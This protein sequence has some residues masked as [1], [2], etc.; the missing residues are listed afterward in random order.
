MAG[1]FN[2]RVYGILI[3]QGS[4]L[5]SEEL[6]AGRLITKFPGGGLE[7]GE[8]PRQCLVREWKEELGWEIDVTGHYYTTDFFQKSAFDDSQVI[9]IYYQVAS[10][11]PFPNLV[12][13]VP[14]HRPFWLEIASITRDTF[15]LPIDIHVGNMLLHQHTRGGL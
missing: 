12:N 11:T 3:D 14:G 4:V 10:K 13:L 2:I 6:I 8:G 15:R 5:V 1:R 7:W 9:S